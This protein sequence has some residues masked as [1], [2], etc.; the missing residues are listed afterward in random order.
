[1]SIRTPSRFFDGL[2]DNWWVSNDPQST[3]PFT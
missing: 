2:Q 1:M 3:L